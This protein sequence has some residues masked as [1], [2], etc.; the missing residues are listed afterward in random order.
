M[1]REAFRAFLAHPSTAARLAAMVADNRRVDAA[2]AATESSSTS[3]ADLQ[4]LE[5]RGTEAARLEP[6]PQRG[7]GFAVR[8][9]R[10]ADGVDQ[11]GDF[12]EGVAVG[13]FG[14]G[15]RERGAVVERHG[16]AHGV[17]RG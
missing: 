10:P 17:V 3:D 9:L 7:A 2:I 8:A 13:A 4:R 16:D 1:T 11:D 14:Q 15:E 12:R 6:V 5:Q